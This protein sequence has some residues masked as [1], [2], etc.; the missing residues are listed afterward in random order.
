MFRLSNFL[1]AMLS[2]LLLV[3]ITGCAGLLAPSAPTPE[4]ITLQFAYPLAEKGEAYEKLA[5][6]FHEAHPNI[7]VEVQHMEDVGYVAS[8][9]S[10]IDAF[11]ADQFEL[12]SLVRSSAV[13]NLD[14][15]LQEN[16]QIAGDLYPRTLQAF[17]WQGQTWGI[18]AD[19]DPWIL[20]YNKDLFDQADVPYPQPGW[21][22]NDFLD[23]A[24][25]LTIDR[26]D[27]MQ[28]GF[29]SNPE[30]APEIIAFIYQNGGS[31]VDNIVDPQEPTF[32]SPATIEAVEWYTDLAL[33]YEVM[34]PPEV[35]GRYRR[36][37]VFEAAFRQQVAM[38]MGPMSVRG[39]LI[40]DFEWP[41]NWGVAPLPQDEEQ[42]TLFLLS[43]YFISANSPHPREAWLW[44]EHVTS[45]PRPVWNL[46]PRRSVAETKLYHQ[47]VGEEVAET[48]LASAEYGLTSPPTPWLMNLFEWLGQALTSI[49]TKEQGIGEA[50]QQ[51]QQKAEAA[52]A[53]QE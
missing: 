29:G 2:A 23:K 17:T 8:E 36:G 53:A 32:D 15:I 47:R 26:G 24:A 46:P 40:W 28:Y 18:P 22:W 42:A 3:S 13:L 49:L 6:E 11:E 12:A 14:P 10:G 35:I 33:E 16:P 34:P 27:H 31:L 39:G 7:T 5:A 52:L 41:F 38:W 43:G 21:A 1:Q 45:S 20:Y 30:E 51:I 44:I 37:G 48:A 4:P 50:M 9:G 19:I 25:R